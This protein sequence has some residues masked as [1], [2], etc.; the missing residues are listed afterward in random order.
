MAKKKL[1]TTELLKNYLKANYDFRYNVITNQVEYKPKENELFVALLDFQ[2]NSLYVEI[3]SQDI[4]TTLTDLKSILY[5]A[6]SDMYNPFKEY[7]ENLPM[8][9]G[10]DYIEQL[11][12][13]V[14]THDNEFFKWSLRKWLVAVVA[15]AIKEK[16][17]N[18]QCIIIAGNQGIGKST[19]IDNLVPKSLMPYYYSGDVNLQNKDT[20]H[21]LSSK[22]LINLDEL[23]NMTYSS[24]TKLKE[25]VTKGHIS[26]RQA[27]SHFNST[28]IRR[29]SFIGSVNGNEFLY[30]L[31]G[32]RRFISIEAFEFINKG[33]HNIN[34]DH[35]YAQAYTLLKNGFV[36]WFNEN[37]EKKLEDNNKNFIVIS[38]EEEALLKLFTPARVEGVLKMG[39]LDAI[40]NGKRSFSYNPIYLTATEIFN[41]IHKWPPSQSTI[42]RFGKILA[43]NGF[44]KVS[45]DHVKKYEVFEIYQEKG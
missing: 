1:N 23:A 29:A 42:S 34:L 3:K 35:V 12:N 27:Y 33:R 38:A 43:K 13:T 11:A 25:I 44:K 16:A 45:K 18:H 41:R 39:T 36:F 14:K 2:L 4:K 26:F 19:W 20:L 5:S 40:A 30:D 8:W 31:T 28:F 9:D 7:F 22:F 6:F 10:I 17:T 15:C 32:N 24:V 37:D 21:Y